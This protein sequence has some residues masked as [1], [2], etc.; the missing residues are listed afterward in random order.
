MHK[1]IDKIRELEE[2]ILKLTEFVTVSELGNMMD[3]SPNDVMPFF[4]C[5]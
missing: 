4:L 1:E 3:K 2:K 5:L